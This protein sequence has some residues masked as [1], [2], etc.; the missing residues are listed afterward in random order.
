MHT[1]DFRRFCCVTSEN[2]FV[3]D[4]KRPSGQLHHRFATP[5]DPRHVG[6]DG[7]VT[8]PSLCPNPVKSNRSTA[9]ADYSL[10][11]SVAAKMSLLH[12]RRWAKS[13]CQRAGPS[14]VS[15][16]AVSTVP[17]ADSLRPPP[18][19]GCGCSRWSSMGARERGAACRRRAAR[20]KLPA[21]RGRKAR[22]HNSARRAPGVRRKFH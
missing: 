8:S 20:A 15:R 3:A 16:R 17:C 22:T 13:S 6:L 9:I 18:N 10:R 11:N 14:G 19:T 1:C 7:H 2:E 4:S 5:F 12:V 21:G